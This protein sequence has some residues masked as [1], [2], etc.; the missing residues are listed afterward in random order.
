MNGHFASVP[1][2]LLR[3]S[4]SLAEH[5]FIHSVPS[6]VKPHSGGSTGTTKPKFQ[7][8]A[9]EPLSSS[10]RFPQTATCVA[11]VSRYDSSGSLTR[12]ISP[13]P[14]DSI[15]LL[16]PLNPISSIISPA[17]MNGTPRSSV[18]IYT[19]S[20]N[21]TETLASE[22]VAP[23]QIDQSR[24]GSY[25]RQ[26][27]LLG[28]TKNDQ[29]AETLMMG[30]GQITG[31]FTLD[32]SLVNQAP[33]EEVKRKGV[34]GGQGGGGVVRTDTGRRE[35]GLFGSIGWGSIGGSLG[36]LLGGN[37]LSSIKETKD[38][39]SMRSIPILSTPQSVLFVNLRLGP[40]ESRTYTYSHPL[41]SGIP[42]THKGR[43]MKISYNL[44]IGTQRAVKTTDNHHIRTV[45]VPFRV[46]SGVNG[47]I[48]PTKIYLF[49][50][51]LRPG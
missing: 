2:H 41:P 51:C 47:K 30:Y 3:A 37:E 14:S 24:N 27:S 46:L 28:P 44:T 31:S 45:E 35:G 5:E 29:A 20:N 1:S 32:G 26:L 34:I 33:F 43:A 12:S 25:G 16:E 49:L 4:S 19:T 36:G 23:D 50:I 10:F 38:T 9:P 17:S 18:E 21:S 42:P 15:N 11:E 6:S 8:K 40:G 39:A 48:F 7:R 13:R 22:Y